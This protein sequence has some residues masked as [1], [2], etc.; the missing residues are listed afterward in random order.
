M[1]VTVTIENMTVVRPTGERNIGT[2]TLVTVIEIAAAATTNVTTET[3]M[4]IAIV[5]IT[6][7]GMM[8]VAAI[9]TGTDAMTLNANADT[10]MMMMT[11]DIPAGGTEMTDTIAT[12][13]T[14][15]IDMTVMI[16]MIEETATVAM[17]V[18]LTAMMIDIPTVAIVVKDTPVD[19]TMMMTEMIDE[20]TEGETMTEPETGQAPV[21][22]AQ[23]LK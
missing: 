7:V 16:E 11:I 5:A 10:L 17:A 9:T 15:E 23:L 18:A 14:D 21:P 8:D 6:P 2:T 22:V 12:M 1:M 3:T 20:D 13:A 19:T 4:M